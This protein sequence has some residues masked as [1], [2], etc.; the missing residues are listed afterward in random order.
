[1]APRVRYK[2]VIKLTMFKEDAVVTAIRMKCEGKSVAD[3]SEATGA[4]PE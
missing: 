1:M 4:P 2:K 3:I